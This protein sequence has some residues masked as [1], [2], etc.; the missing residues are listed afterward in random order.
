MNGLVNPSI[1]RA[2]KRRQRERERERERGG[3][4]RDRVKG[5]RTR[6]I[7]RVG[8]KILREMS[9]LLFRNCCN[10]LVNHRDANE[11]Q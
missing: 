8:G 7:N 10:F 5:G 9:L 6:E 4:E 1:K 2:F 11:K 3:R